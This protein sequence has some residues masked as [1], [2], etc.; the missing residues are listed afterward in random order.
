MSLRVGWAGGVDV[1]AAGRV[2]GAGEQRGCVG[3]GGDAGAD[4]V[5]A[6]RRSTEGGGRGIGWGVAADGGSVAVPLRGRRRCRVAGPAARRTAGAGAGRGSGSGLGVDP[7]QPTGRDGPVALVEPR[8]RRVHPAHR[9]RVRL[10][11]LRGEAVAG[12]R[13]EAAPARHVQAQQGPGSSPPRSPTS[14]ACTSSR[15]A[16]R[17]CSRSMR[18]RRSRPWTG[19]SRCCRSR[20]TRPR[21]APTT[22]CGTARRTCSPR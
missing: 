12:D 8:A 18:K 4:R 11:P 1:G 17:W 2:G 19:P 22:T 21:S 14:W 16:V 7:D 13:V 15:R 3:V 10:A 6:G 20:S 5:V 9:G